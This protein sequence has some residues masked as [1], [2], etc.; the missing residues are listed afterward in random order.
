MPLVAVGPL[1]VVLKLLEVGVVANW[2]WLWV[3]APFGLAMAWWIW[4]DSTGHTQRQA[5]R[6][7]EE[8][9]VARRERDIEALGLNVNSDRRRR[10]TERAARAARSRTDDRKTGS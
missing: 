5:M 6:R 4:S 3:L 2:S 8:R 10:A 7:T 9:K 1:L